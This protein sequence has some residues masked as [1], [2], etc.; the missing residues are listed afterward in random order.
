HV[1]I[2]LPIMQEQVVMIPINDQYEGIVDSLAEPPSSI[3]A[4]PQQKVVKE[5]LM[6]RFA[7]NKRSAILDDYVVYLGDNAYDIGPIIDLI[8]YKK[9]ISSSHSNKWLD[10][11]KDEINSMNHNGV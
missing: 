9:A 8:I 6:L 4:F 5:V 10:A 11:M 7:R 2:T 1:F 3:K